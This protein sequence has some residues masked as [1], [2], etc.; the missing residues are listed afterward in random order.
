MN[1]HGNETVEDG[2]SAAEVI[3]FFRQS[4]KQI[5][6]SG[7][8]GGALAFGYACIFPSTY[9]AT[10]YVQV[11]KV[12][13]SDV[14]TYDILVEKL[15]VPTYYTQTTFVACNLMGSADPGNDIAKSLKLTLL[16]NSQVLSI[17]YKEKSAENAK[18][19]LEGVFAEIRASQNILAKP[20]LEAKSN[21]LT[22]LKEKMDFLE[23]AKKRPSIKNPNSDFSNPNALISSWLLMAMN[24][25][26]EISKLE[27][28]LTEPQTRGASLIVPIYAPDN[29]VGPNINRIVLLGGVSGVLL[30]IAYL[31]TRRVWLKIKLPNKAL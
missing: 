4:W 14:E 12:A 27:I 21:Q 17:T 9:L 2:L 22:K 10:A 26:H 5:L 8:I 15:K 25:D 7:V 24:K 28:E 29:R 1:G 18:K 6:F 19:C 16:K 13:G 23:N 11:A 20:I 30:A 3:V 31:I